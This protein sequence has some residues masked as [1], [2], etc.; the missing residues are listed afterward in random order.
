MK[1]G[2]GGLDLLVK[3]FG[4]FQKN[5][6]FLKKMVF[7]YIFWTFYFLIFFHFSTILDFW[8]IYFGFLSERFCIFW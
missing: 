5:Y 4:F 8:T 1:G 2:R 6:R 3:F 7:L